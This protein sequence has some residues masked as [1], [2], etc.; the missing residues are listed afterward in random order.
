MRKRALIVMVVV[1]ML[2]V[3]SVSA[4]DGVNLS[5]KEQIEASA[6]KIKELQQQRIAILKDV[7]EICTQ[8]YQRGRVSFEEVLEAN[9]QLLNAELDVAEKES[10]RI[11]LYKNTVE[12]LKQYEQT[13]AAA[14]DAARGTQAALL[15]IRARRLEIE[16]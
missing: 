14:V 2:Q 5:P 13:A 6:K 15:K 1:A 3:L 16:I 9:L 10:D 12:M 8:V 7:V 11:E 4:E